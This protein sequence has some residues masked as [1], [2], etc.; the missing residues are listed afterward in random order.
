[1]YCSKCGQKIIEGQQF[2]GSCGTNITSENSSVNT[3]QS[4]INDVN[5]MVMQ[6]VPNN[7]NVTTKKCKEFI[8]SMSI[9]IVVSCALIYFSFLLATLV[10]GI[11]VV[12]SIIFILPGLFLMYVLFATIAAA[13]SK[14][15][16]TMDNKLK[17][18]L[19]STV[20]QD[21]FLQ[22]G[23]I[24]QRQYETNTPNIQLLE[25]S[26]SFVIMTY[27]IIFYPTLLFV[28]NII[29]QVSDIPEMG[30]QSQGYAVFFTWLGSMFLYN[31]ALLIFALAAKSNIK[32]I[33]TTK[34]V[35]IIVWVVVLCFTFLSF[36]TYGLNESTGV[37]D[38]FFVIFMIVSIILQ[39]NKNKQQK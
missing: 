28:N 33:F 35:A 24:A 32:A 15:I 3:P 21:S 2:C 18:Y 7:G 8:K 5:N 20:M 29:F 36:A 16:N 31:L 38:A 11:N 17:K 10:T 37:F 13:L 9:L 23:I 22:K 12:I 34:K 19:G 30:T 39:C 14:D 25:Y 1:M 27:L 4:N 6:T 26:K